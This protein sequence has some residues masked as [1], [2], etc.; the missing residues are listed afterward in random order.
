MVT[1]ILILWL[2]AEQ[3]LHGYRIK[4][5]LSDPSLGFWF[6]VEDASIY[7]MLRTLEKEGL[8][9]EAAQER[10]GKRPSRVLYAIT[11]PGRRVLRERLQEAW[12]VT[13]RGPE[14]IN[15]ALAAADE[16]EDAEVAELLRDRLAAVAR[17]REELRG[18]ALGSP[19][20]LLARREQALLEAELRWLRREVA[21]LDETTA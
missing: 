8:A 18:V 15:A 19:S 17:R 2:L 1:R 6:P 13:R 9:R 20:R 10:V 11:R 7:S 21:T 4:K 14:V 5:I 3:P 16:F 12:L